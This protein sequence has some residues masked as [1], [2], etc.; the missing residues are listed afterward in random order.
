MKT[1]FARKNPVS[2]SVSI[3]EYGR[4]TRHAFTLVELLVVI[5]II[6]ILVALLLPAIQ[7][8]RE[9]ARRNSC[10]N[11]MKQLGLA[12]HNHLDARK[13][14]P[15]N[16][17]DNPITGCLTFLLPYMEENTV[18]KQYN[19]KKNWSAQT[20]DVLNAWVN[21]FVC[22][23]TAT[24]A[25]ERKAPTDY[26]PI[27]RI[28][29]SVMDTWLAKK[30]ITKRNYT[31]VDPKK[32]G[33]APTDIAGVLIDNKLRKISAVSD[34]LSKTLLFVE[35]AGMPL[36]YR[37][38]R[39]APVLQT[40]TYEFAI[41]WYLDQVSFSVSEVPFINQ[42]NETEIYS[43]HT[44][45]VTYGRCDGSAHFMNEE[46]DPEPFLSLVTYNSGDLVT[47]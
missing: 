23:S 13:G 40:D 20:K 29:S 22:P 30:Q 46:I 42:T 31:W 21:V 12:V 4:G 28:K 2:R 10:L 8:A 24:S 11:N 6:G 35:T 44:G 1:C 9:A 47:E 41:H 25:S 5:A 36:G 14:L 18:Y 39:A 32:P 7:A 37:V 15:Q 33:T 45:G 38:G 3:P 43:F 26:A 27:R 17:I 34:G 16:R 19:F